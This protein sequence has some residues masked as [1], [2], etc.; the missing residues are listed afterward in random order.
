MDD[1]N[2]V[3]RLRRERREATRRANAMREEAERASAAAVARQAALLAS[4]GSAMVR[5]N[6]K[7]AILVRER[8]PFGTSRDAAAWPIASRSYLSSMRGEPP[9]VTATAYLY[10]S[11]TGGLYEDGRPV[12]DRSL[13][14]FEITPSGLGETLEA[15]AR[16]LGVDWRAP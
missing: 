15:A 16:S 11:S 8:G 9:F 10:V 7:R 3:K 12:P 13:Q 2:I 4:F 1:R 14:D 6:A 5:A